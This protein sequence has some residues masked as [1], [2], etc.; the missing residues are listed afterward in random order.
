MATI[1]ICILWMVISTLAFLEYSDCC[2]GLIFSEMIIVSLIFI[3]G[4]PFF[5]ITNIL[6]L[7]LSCIL[8]EGWDDEDKG[9]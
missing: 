6:T 8:P 5:A 4:G 2:S 9:H 3:V 7:I 1:I